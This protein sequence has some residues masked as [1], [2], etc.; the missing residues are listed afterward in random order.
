MQ[1]EMYLQTNGCAITMRNVIFYRIL[2]ECR[3]KYKMRGSCTH[4]PA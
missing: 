2:T 3:K 1:D 4:D